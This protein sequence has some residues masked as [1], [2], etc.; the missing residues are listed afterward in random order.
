MYSYKYENRGVVFV[1]DTKSFYASVEAVAHGLHPMKVPL[2]VV[3]TGPNVGGGGLILATSP[4]AKKLYGLKSNVSR[5]KDIK[6]IKDLIQF[7]PRMNLYIKKNLEI[8]DVYRQFAADEDI[9]PYSIDESI[10]D[11]TASWKLFG[12]TPAEVARKIQIA[13]KNETGLYT[14]VGIGDNPTQAKIALDTQA[15]KAKSLIGE[16]SQ[17]SIPDKL[18]PIDQLDSIWSIGKRTALK[19]ETM[20]IHSMYELA[21]SD[22][23]E[24][25]KKFGP[26]NG[27]RLYALAWG[28]D[29]TKI[30][31]RVNPKSKSLG[32][33][34][35]LPRDYSKKK[36]IAIVVREI[37][38]QV[39]SRVRYEHF[40]AGN[41][42][43]YV[44]NEYGGS[45]FHKVS[46]F[47]TPTNLTRD[48]QQAAIDLLNKYWEPGTTRNVALYCGNLTPDNAQQLDLFTDVSTLE[49]KEK[50]DKAI[51]SVRQ[52]YGFT[53]LV[54]HSSTKEAGTAI[55]RAS[56]VGG[57]NGGN[58]YE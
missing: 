51:D 14:T 55:G 33:S 5:I 19:L 29:R 2:V 41:V 42:S 6:H 58:T 45:G 27:L 28:V 24:L 47:T 52:K 9:L 18:W 37:A 13:V 20:G 25:R 39:A 30:S 32:N 1:I 10:I 17:E 8:N 15:K 22:P 26:N 36:D 50:L 16:L 35:V 3:S 7:P 49:K 23:F 46:K 40:L 57:H 44:G 12:K 34:Q 11:M 21:H 54:N 43:L 56:L 48:I 38:D 53:K 31:E 4:M